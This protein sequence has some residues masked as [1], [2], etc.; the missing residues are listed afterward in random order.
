MPITWFVDNQRGRLQTRAVGRISYEEILKHLEVEGRERALG[1]H[2]LFD[3]DDATTTLTGDQVR[4]LVWHVRHLLA[5]EPFGP[6]AIVAT[7]D[8]VY[9]MA[10]MLAIWC[11]DTGPSFGVFR[12]VATAEGWLDGLAGS[13]PAS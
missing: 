9:G 4:Q 8:L 6:T 7:N 10:R 1:Y 2:E 11:E 12:D 13:E 5:R 3:A